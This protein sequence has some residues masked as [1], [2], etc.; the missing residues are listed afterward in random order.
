V[1]RATTDLAEW[2]DRYGLGEYVQT[3]AENHI[4]ETVLPDLTDADLKTLGVSLGH[5][6]KLLRAY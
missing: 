5:R 6:K 3:F 2:L 1:T 4:D